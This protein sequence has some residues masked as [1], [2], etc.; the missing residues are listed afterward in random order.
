MPKTTSH[1]NPLKPKVCMEKTLPGHSRSVA[2]EVAQR[3]LDDPNRYPSEHDEDV[4]RVVTATTIILSEIADSVSQNSKANA[5]A[6]FI[7]H[8]DCNPKTNR[9][10][11]MAKKRGEPFYGAIVSLAFIESLY[12]RVAGMVHIPDFQ[13]DPGAFVAFASVTAIAHE[14]SHGI[15]GH[16]EVDTEDDNELYWQELDADRRS[17]CGSVVVA[18]D[19]KVFE[20][21]EEFFGLRDRIGFLEVATFAQSLLAMALSGS[22]SARYADSALRSFLYFEGFRSVVFAKWIANPLEVEGA[23]IRSNGLARKAVDVIPGGQ[24]I[25]KIRSKHEECEERWQKGLKEKLFA[26]SDRMIARSPFHV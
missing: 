1:D 7:L 11:T 18:V 22:A 5:Q 23:R 19:T 17:G 15:Y 25:V 26:Y 10:A 20:M 16:S 24:E 2:H 3:Y 12:D 4:R 8:F 14:F 13:L 9:P 6:E 21:M